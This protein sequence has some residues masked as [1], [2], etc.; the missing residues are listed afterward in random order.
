MCEAII[1]SGTPGTGKTSVAKQLSRRLGW[2]YISLTEVA[3]NEGFIKGEDKERET[4]IIDEEQLRKYVRELIKSREKLVIDSHYGEIIDDYLVKKIFVLRLHPKIL[5][6]RLRSRNYPNHK[7]KENLEAELVGTCTYS[8]LSLHPGKVCEVDATGKKVDEVVQE[9]LDVLNM[10][11][12]C[13]VWV[14]WLS[15]KIPEDI[16]KLVLR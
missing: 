2:A 3:I 15:E 12:K 16:L 6:D 7:I 1:I 14:D 8:A 11:V 4:L 13:R 9:I 5:L 10:R